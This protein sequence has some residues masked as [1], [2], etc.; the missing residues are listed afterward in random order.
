MKLKSMIALIC[1]ASMAVCTSCGDN[2]DSDDPELRMPDLK[3]MDVGGIEEKYD[4]L[5]ITDY[6]ND[7]SNEYEEGKIMDQSIRPGRKIE[8]GE[9]VEITI[10]M[11]EKKELFRMTDMTGLDFDTALNRYK[12]HIELKLAGVE[13]SE[14]FGENEIIW[15]SISPGTEYE[16]G[17]VMEVKVSSGSEKVEVPDITNMNKDLAK[18]QLGLLGLDAE[19]K[20]QMDS[21]TSENCVIGTEPKAG[22]QVDKGSKI[23]VYVSLGGASDLIEVENFVG[24]NAKDAAM[25][26]QYYGLSVITE[27]IDSSAEE[28]TVLEQSIREGERVEKGTEIILYISTG[29]A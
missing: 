27:P 11:G 28:G 24:K 10:S 20:M 17:V 8:E 29:T 18:D 7:Y 5:D 1:A 12:G 2:S 4:Y 19:I 16:K 23:I 15:Q 13:Y 25:T 21:A 22:E 9:K 6:L 3:G 14:E 26:A